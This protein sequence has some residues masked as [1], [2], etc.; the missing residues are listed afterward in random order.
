MIK[1][2]V[3]SSLPKHAH[4]EHLFLIKAR[5][6]VLGIHR[7]VFQATSDINCTKTT[8]LSFAH[9]RH[10]TKFKDVLVNYQK[11]NKVMDRRLADTNTLHFVDGSSSSQLPL[12]IELMSSMFLEYTCLLNYFDMYIIDEVKVAS[13]R[14]TI[15]CYEFTSDEIP[16]RTFLNKLY[17]NM[18]K[19]NNPI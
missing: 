2:N 19:G 6:T 10:A 5:G 13:S 1:V 16:N 3:I 11:K 18:L 4:Y 17:H 7:N 15:N 14:I 9:L 12:E 8:L